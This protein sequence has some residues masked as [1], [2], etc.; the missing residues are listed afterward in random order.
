MGGNLV[1]EQFFSDKNK[2]SI[3]KTLLLAT[4]AWRSG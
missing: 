1:S 2:G 4:S 3:L